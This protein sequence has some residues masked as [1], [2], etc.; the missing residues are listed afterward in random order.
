LILENIVFLTGINV[1]PRT[2]R[3]AQLAHGLFYIYFQLRG[4]P[5]C[6]L[7]PGKSHCH[8]YK[9]WLGQIHSPPTIKQDQQ[10]N[11][12]RKHLDRTKM[13]DALG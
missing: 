4:T 3:V 13:L 1:S 7:S 10:S 12:K 2:E 9:Q 11:G 5:N 8:G 6:L